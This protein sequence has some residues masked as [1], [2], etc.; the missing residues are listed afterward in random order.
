[1]GQAI[2]EVLIE[3]QIILIAKLDNADSSLAIRPLRN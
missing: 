1:V 2:L 3:A